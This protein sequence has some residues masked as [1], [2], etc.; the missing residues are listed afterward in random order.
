[1]GTLSLTPTEGEKTWQQQHTRT[2]AHLQ[3]RHWASST[4]HTIR[5][6]LRAIGAELDA[7]LRG[8]RTSSITLNWRRLGRE[9]FG[10]WSQRQVPT[11]KASTT[12]P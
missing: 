2:P 1:M 10:I 11:P 8:H 6:L 12:F 9:R 5:V 7:T 4:G 3:Q